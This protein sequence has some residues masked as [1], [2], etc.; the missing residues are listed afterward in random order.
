ME[1][2]IKQCTD[3]LKEHSLPTEYVEKIVT[4]HFKNTSG[5]YSTIGLSENNDWRVKID[6]EHSLK[7]KSHLV[8]FNKELQ[9]KY[10]NVYHFDPHDLKHIHE[11]KN[12]VRPTKILEKYFIAFYKQLEMKIAHLSG[13]PAK[14]RF[15]MDFNANLISISEFFYRLLSEKNLLYTLSEDLYKKVPP[16]P[17][18]LSTLQRWYG[19]YI[20][21]DRFLYLSANP[22]DY[23]TMSNDN[24][25]Y[26]TYSSCLRPDG[27]F[28][29]TV[30]NYLNSPSV[31]VS[32]I[33]E[34]N[35]SVKIGRTIVYTSKYIICTSRRYGIMSIDDTAA[36]RD[37]LKSC[38]SGTWVSCGKMEKDIVCDLTQSYLDYGYGHTLLNSDAEKNPIEI[39]SGICLS[40]GSKSAG[41]NE[42][43]GTC[44]ECFEESEYCFMCD[45][46][47]HDFNYLESQ[48]GYLCDNC[49]DE[50]VISCPN[51]GENTLRNKILKVHSVN[52]DTGRKK[53]F[54]YCRDC[55]PSHKRCSDCNELFED[56][57]ISYYCSNAF[58]GNLC[59]HCRK[60]R[61]I[62]E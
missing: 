19:E 1:K 11:G 46:R 9:K 30:L 55:C 33:T 42:C 47:G 61:K 44:P 52:E 35:K 38:I 14:E 51:C 31:F 40:C 34:P 39:H 48:D 49:W 12:K 32:Y 16:S 60:E 45:R 13:T 56:D 27:E 29:N 23:L 18:L 25:K 2:V 26:C 57:L 17:A 5:F 10:P 24:A 22:Y 37:Y 3:Y 62:D 21:S 28:F 54:A 4:N 7:S 43:G 8:R 53:V 6:L 59:E 15:F 58:R 20:K 50:H 41:E 36:V